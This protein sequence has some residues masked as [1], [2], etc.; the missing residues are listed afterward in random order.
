MKF[1]RLDGGGVTEGRPVVEQTGTSA[2]A[3]G[4]F[5]DAET[6]IWKPDIPALFALAGGIVVRIDPRS[7][8]DTRYVLTANK[9]TKAQAEAGTNNAKWM[10]PLRTAQA[11]EAQRGTEVS[12]AYVV[13]I[14]EV[15]TFTWPQ[16]WATPPKVSLTA[17]SEVSTRPNVAEI[18]SVTTTDVTIRCWRIAALSISRR[19][20]NVHVWAK[21]VLA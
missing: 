2:P 10:T 15:E 20:M 17:V 3:A 18:V 11:V 4:A 5:P 16:S 12:R 13:N 8:A 7:V 14:D 19:Q 9:A 6:F 21:G 1:L